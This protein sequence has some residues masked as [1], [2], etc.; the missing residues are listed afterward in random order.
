[1]KLISERIHVY[2]HS[3]HGVLTPLQFIWRNKTFHV[4]DIQHRSRQQIH[5]KTFYTF[6]LT[7]NPNGRCE[8]E[9]DMTAGEW[10]LIRGEFDIDNGSG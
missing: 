7:T 6:R 9:F 3:R 10:L 8:I 2:A 1:M 5:G 4:R